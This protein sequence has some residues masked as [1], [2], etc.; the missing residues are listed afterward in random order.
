[1]KLC[2][3]FIAVAM[4]ISSNFAD[5]AI[6]I[7]GGLSLYEA[8]FTYEPEGQMTSEYFG[9]RIGPNVSVFGEIAQNRNLFH[10]VQ[11][12]Y[13]QAGG[14]ASIEYTTALDGNVQK[15]GGTAWHDFAINYVGLG[16]N[17]IYKFP[18]SALIPYAS[19]GASADYLINIKERINWK[20]PIEELHSFDNVTLN[21]ANVRP[22][23]S[24]GIEYKLS[25]VSL[26]LEYT[27]SYN[28]LPFYQHSAGE[29]NLGVKHTT[30]GHL[31]NIGC[32]FDI[33]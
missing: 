6:G 27:F 19:I 30:S 28:L 2:L 26:L 17:F 23:I 29:T 1:M 33:K 9:L 31:I 8:R 14:K 22:L 25:K 3:A 12:S 18:I 7:K 32:K 16:Y 24:T 21:R 10:S 4:A 20:G 11:L 5:I 13:Y 15:T